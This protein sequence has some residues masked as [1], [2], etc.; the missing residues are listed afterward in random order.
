M[1]LL[2]TGSAGMLGL[3]LSGVALERGYEVV[4]LDL[5]NCDIAI[6]MTD[7]AALI[8]ALGVV[9]PDVVV[10][11]AAIVD[12]GHCE[13]DPLLSWRVNA[14]CVG[15]MAHYC[16]SHHVR[17]VQISTDHYFCGDMDKK[18]DELAPVTFLN[19]YARAK[20]AG[21][22]FAAIG[23]TSLV[24]RTNIVGFRGRATKT[25]A[26]WAFDAV[27]HDREITLFRDAY[28]STIDVRSFSGALLDMIER[29][30][31]GLFNLANHDVFSKQALI[32]CIARQLGV[33]LSRAKTGS[34]AALSVAR[35]DSCGLDV[36][37]AERALGYELPD[38]DQVVCNLVNEW[39][40]IQKE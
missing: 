35:A 32:E 22:A 37:R 24:L 20:F 6:D 17:L 33:S 21:E 39:K 27:V 13:Q 15:V 40:K 12:V 38:L 18:H 4:G 34:V 29:K 31:S 9:R 7:D 5:A 1:K 25:F 28:V 8:A 19:E 36:S 14:R 30:E 2:V 10:N 16:R 26:E 23:P 11:C 3:K